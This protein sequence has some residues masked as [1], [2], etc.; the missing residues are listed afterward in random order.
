MGPIHLIYISMSLV[1]MVTY[2]TAMLNKQV[3]SHDCFY[4]CFVLQ[5]IYLVSAQRFE[6]FHMISH[7]N[8][9]FNLVV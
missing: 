7:Q 5:A 4:N 8:N 3:M 1:T 9:Y 2:A 6:G